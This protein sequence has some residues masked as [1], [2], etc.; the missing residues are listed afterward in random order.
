[1][2][3]AKTITYIILTLAVLAI[4]GIAGWFIYSFVRNGQKSFYVSYGETKISSGV[5]EIELPANTT[6]FFTGRTLAGT[7]AE[8]TKVDNYT[9][10]VVP[11]QALVRSVKYRIGDEKETYLSGDTDFSKT[12]NVKKD[13]ATFSIF[14]PLEVDL[15]SAM[16]EALGENV[17]TLNNVP[18]ESGTYFNLVI[19]Y[20]AENAK[21]IIPLTLTLI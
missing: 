11:T 10:S 3:T 7:S 21:I 8:S 4:V 13:G 6:I 16:T 5:S 9:V 2:K 14:I 15:K 20:A 19:E 12:F 17:D 1:M 18:E